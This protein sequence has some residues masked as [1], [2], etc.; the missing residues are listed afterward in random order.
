ME[1]QEA[2]L[3]DLWRNEKELRLRAEARLRAYAA[4]L[5]ELALRLD[6]QKFEELRRL[7]PAAVAAW[8]PEEWRRYFD[9]VRIVKSSEAE[10][11]YREL[12]LLRSQVQELRRKLQDAAEI[13]AQVPQPQQ[14]KAERGEMPAFVSPFPERPPAGWK[15]GPQQ[16][17][18]ARII[19]EEL[20]QGRCL[21][22][23]ILDKVGELEGISGKAGSLKRL[24]VRLVEEGYLAQEVLSLER[25]KTSV[26]V[27]RWG[28]E[29]RKLC[30]RLKVH[31]LP[32]EYERLRSLHQ[33]Q[34]GEEAHTAL[35]LLAAYQAR[36]RG[37][38]SVVLPDAGPGEPDLL[39]R[40]NGE[41][42]YVEVERGLGEPEKRE[43]K[44]KLNRRL[45][46]G[47]AVVIA[48]D[49]STLTRL[50]YD[51]IAPPYLASSME[52]LLQG[53]ESLWEK[54]AR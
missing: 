27:L 26:A 47:V 50:L 54:E 44:W 36:K 51:E 2:I 48:P 18:R 52:Y 11:L 25:P 16:W 7:D 41:E 31:P 17:R 10:A 13:V 35:V 23:E 19:F 22:V 1:V 15:L 12:A 29:G 24:V 42:L 20:A 46:G 34:E 9:G 33:S 4:L 21:R 43:R 6:G 14:E 32:T 5:E 40:R 45:N 37:Y 28:S 53:G 8:G 3:K 39:V 38:D 49:E 30:E